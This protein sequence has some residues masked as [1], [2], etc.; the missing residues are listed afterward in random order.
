MRQPNNTAD[1]V[2]DARDEWEGEL[3]KNISPH[4]P[5]PMEGNKEIMHYGRKPPEKRVQMISSQGSAR[6]GQKPR[7]TALRRWHPVKR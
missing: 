5:E 6:R 7:C 4:Q 2:A 3:Q 1:T